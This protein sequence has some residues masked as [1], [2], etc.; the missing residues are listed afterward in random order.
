MKTKT[1][2]GVIISVHP[3]HLSESSRRFL[4]GLLVFMLAVGSLI[5]LSARGQSNYTGAYYFTTF[6][7]A[8]IGADNTGKLA[9]FDR[10]NSTAV[11]RAGNV[12][13]ADFNDHTVRKI[14]PA[15]VVT[16][17]AGFA[18][19]GEVGDRDGTGIDARLFFPTG[20]AVDSAGNIYVTEQQGYTIRKITPA[21]VVS[22]LAG[23]FGVAGSADGTGSAAR[24][25]Y[26]VGIAVDSG[27]NVYVS[28]ILNQTIRKITPA[29]VVTTIAGA[30][31]VTGSTDGPGAV[32]RF[33]NPAD[34]A[35]DSTGN[36]YVADNFNSTIRKIVLGSS[37]RDITV[38][39]F[40]G[41]AGVVGNTDGTGA[42]AS[43]NGPYGLSVDGAG[44][45]YVADTLQ[46]HYPQDYFCPGSEHFCRHRRN[47]RGGGR[48]RPR[49]AV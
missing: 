37:V 43:F 28:E 47:L 5:A 45:V 35:I 27:G 1:P 4:R 8:A 6:A 16:T 38:S 13:V 31:G 34:L 42:A 40:A 39:T 3:T 36:L 30:A 44:N 49:G 21:G 24:F 18:G 26:P 29:G 7:G 41:T 22:T 12:Y 2:T 48:H 46:P 25:F 19:D 11:D 20:I 33:S 17:L 32:S 9:L 23:T 14:T 15:G 10:P